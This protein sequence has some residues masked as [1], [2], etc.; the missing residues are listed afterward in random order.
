[1]W[2]REVVSEC[3]FVAVFAEVVESLCGPFAVDD[4][5]NEDGASWC[6]DGVLDFRGDVTDVVHGSILR[7]RVQGVRHNGHVLLDKWS[8]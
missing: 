5:S 2:A 3:V 1:M 8:M 6:G 7:I 4:A